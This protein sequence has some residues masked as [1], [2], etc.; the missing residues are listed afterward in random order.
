MEADN[1]MFEMMERLVLRRPYV[2]HQ[3][4]QVMIYSKAVGI[5]LIHISSYSSEIMVSRKT[6][7]DCF[8][9]L[10]ESVSSRTNVFTRLKNDYP[11]CYRYIMLT[12]TGRKTIQSYSDQS[13]L[14]WECS[15]DGRE[16][17]WE[18]TPSGTDH[19]SARH[20]HDGRWAGVRF[21][22]EYRECEVGVGNGE[23]QPRTRPY[24][25]FDL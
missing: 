19:P 23:S 20:S 24:P 10:I 16:I 4:K 21:A 9:G 18:E 6:F 1:E 7:F 2:S 22:C 17:E 12:F 11:F 25:E 8:V 15:Q 5:S 13:R 3:A 14:A